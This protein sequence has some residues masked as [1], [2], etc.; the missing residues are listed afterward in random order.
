M[1]QQLK[2]ERYPEY[3]DSGENW[4]GFVPVHWDIKSL[5]SILTE[6]KENNDPIKTREILSLSMDKGVTL[7]SE[8]GSGGNKAKEDITAYKIAHPNDI[9]IN[10]MNVIVGS[11]GLSKYFGAVSPVY[12][13]LYVRDQKTNIYYYDK[14]FQNPAFQMSLFGLGNGILIK[15]SE[16][17]GKLNTIRL[18][19]PMNKLNKVLF[20]YPPI[21]E[22]KRIAEFLDIK[23]TQIDQAISQKQQLI[24]LLKE[25]RQIV[26]HNAVTRGLNPDAP[27]KSSGVDWIGDIPTHWQIKKIKHICSINPTSKPT[28][29]D[30]TT[31]VEFIPME[32]V[33]ENNGIIKKYNFRKLKE[34]SQGYTSFRNNDIIFAKITPCMENGNCAIV[35]NLSNDI[36]Y[37]STEF[38]VF[39]SNCLVNNGFLYLL[40]RS[41]SLR[42][43]F[44]TNMHGS[45]GQKRIGTDFIA[46]FLVTLPPIDEQKRIIEYIES[47]KTKIEAAITCKQNEIEKLKEYK[48]TLINSAVTGKIRV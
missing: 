23:T 22:Q 30:R 4:L 45:A 6:R 27:I 34:V 29:L 16:Q 35:S 26:I 39:R 20:P 18:R 42:N 43:I 7:Y 24:E 15:K 21:E 1:E 41:K 37:G 14:I 48:T 25:R 40:L 31:I 33:D 32:N 17:S 19:I 44:E 46:N 11:V 2:F 36:C 47:V 38:V 9:V 5:K 3:K 28:E 10:S 8:K 13:T 12:Y